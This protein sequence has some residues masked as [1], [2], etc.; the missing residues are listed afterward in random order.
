MNRTLHFDN[1]EQCYAHNTK[2]I[3]LGGSEEMKAIVAYCQNCTI[4]EKNIPN[5]FPTYA[6]NLHSK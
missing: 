5:N 3:V 2:R 4:M 1:H 6:E